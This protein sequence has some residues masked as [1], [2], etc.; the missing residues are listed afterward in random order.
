MDFQKKIVTKTDYLMGRVQPA[1]LHGFRGIKISLW[2]STA[3]QKGGLKMNMDITGIMENAHVVILPVV[4]GNI[5]F[6][7]IHKYMST[8]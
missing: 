1:I 8:D 3:F 2:F 5:T 6:K 4:T 7:I